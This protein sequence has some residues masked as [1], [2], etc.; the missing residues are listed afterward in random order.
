[1]K[2]YRVFFFFV[3]LRVLRG[4][5]SL[6]RKAFSL[7]EL[8]IVISVLGIMA[9]IVLPTLQDHSQKAKE[10]A[11]KDNLRILRTAIELYAAQHNDVPPG[12]INDDPAR[13]P[14]AIIFCLQMVPGHLR[15]M[16]LNPINGLNTLDTIMNTMPFPAAPD[17]NTAY[18]YKPETR[19]LRLNSTGTDS[20][21]LAYFE[22]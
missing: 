8:L 16:P 18:I 21:G 19:E 5:K 10:A 11:A 15:T 22:Y 13:V 12:Y 7:I 20:E 4:W 6:M 2:H 9:A 14:S 3:A 17:D 1:M